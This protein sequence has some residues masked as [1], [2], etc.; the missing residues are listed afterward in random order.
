VDRHSVRQSRKAQPH[1]TRVER[2]DLLLLA[3]LFRIGKLPHAA[4]RH[5]GRRPVARRVR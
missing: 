5:P 2:P 4:A 1:L 3:C